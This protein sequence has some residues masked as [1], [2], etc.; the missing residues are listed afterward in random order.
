ML[1]S[2]VVHEIPCSCGE[3]YIGETKKALGTRLKEQQ[4]ATRRG[5][6]EKSANAEHP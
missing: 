2:S 5:Q 3:R 4:A 1:W 6:T